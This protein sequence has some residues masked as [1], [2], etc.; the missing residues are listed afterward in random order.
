MKITDK[1]RLDWLAGQHKM[2]WDMDLHNALPGGKYDG[3]YTFSDDHEYFQGPLRRAI[4]AAIRAG[5]NKT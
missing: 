4:D 3:L 1:M 5:R 2:S